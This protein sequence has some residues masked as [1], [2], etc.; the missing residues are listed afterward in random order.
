M[1]GYAIWI[2]GWFHMSG[3]IRA[4]HVL[5]DELRKRG[6]SAHMTYES[7]I[8]SGEIVVY[9][10]IVV[11]NPERAERYV[12]W[13]LNY[14]D[15]PEG[16]RAFAWE[17]GMG[18]WPLLTVDI[19]EQGLWTPFEGP[20]GGVGYWV[21]KGAAD[22]SQVPDGAVE[23]TRSNFLTRVE[24]ANFLRTLDYFI[25]FDP[26]SAINIEAAVSGT[27]VLILG[28]HPRWSRDKF[29][30]HDWIRHGVAW[31]W[32]ELGKAREEAHLAFH[33]YQHKRRQ[34]TQRIDS[35]V[36]LTQEWFA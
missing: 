12:H 1:R 32:A 22:M 13:L 8:Q 34:F 17:S 4:L 36:T 25:S 9:P 30:E 31:S 16:G 14:A 19:L 27:P 2:G 28:E 3:G 24:L 10:E 5:R 35:F 15:V 26:F 23:V 18:D 33:D 11:G 20:R 29:E 6:C 21:G 7:P